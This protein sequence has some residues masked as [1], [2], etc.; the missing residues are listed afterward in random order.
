MFLEANAS[1]DA[2]R[3]VLS[4][5]K[6]LSFIS[7]FWS[8]CHGGLDLRIIEKYSE[9]SFNMFSCSLAFDSAQLHQ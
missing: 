8:S 4:F 7:E 2:S 3:A 9:A 6:R 5:N 1:Y